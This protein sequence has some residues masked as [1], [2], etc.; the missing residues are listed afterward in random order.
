M[1]FG[2]WLVYFC[3]GLVAA[4]TAP[5]VG[6][7][8]RDLDLSASEMGGV[9]GAWQLVYIVFAMPCG[10]LLD[11]FG[12]RRAIAAAAVIIALSGA[13]RGLA[14]GW[15]ELFLAVAL[16]GVGGP[17]ISVGAPKVIALWFE[18]AERAFAMGLYITGPALGNIVALSLTNAVAMPLL[19]D[20]R[21]VM[22]AYAATALLGAAAWAVVSAHP[23]SRAS[24]RRLA[25]EPARPQLGVFTALA[26][27]PA[28]QTMLAIGLGVFFINHGFMNWLPEMLR[29]RGFGPADAG[30]WASLP[31]VAGIAGSLLIPRFASPA[32]RLSILLALFVAAGLATQLLHAVTT[33]GLVLGLI[34][35]GV[36]R[37]AMMTVAVLTLLELRGVGARNAGAATGLF[38]AAAEIGGVLGPLAIGVLHDATGEFDSGLDLLG[39]I[40]TALVLLGLLLTRLQKQGSST[41]W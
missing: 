20:W 5:L 24:E 23:A 6:P 35:Q 36:A 8:A 22:T 38:F 19:G 14:G 29:S 12:P 9:L 31:V 26:R 3:F 34:L 18:G 10:A 15:L 30:F 27:L 7:I 13:W 37:G 4:S 1:L 32:R 40:A 41:G 39:V 21:A 11:R 16:F 2:A 33:P 25:A 17:L 28:V